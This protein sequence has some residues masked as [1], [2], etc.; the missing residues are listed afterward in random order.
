MS[1][2][3]ETTVKVS[4]IL[5]IVVGVMPLL[6]RRSAALRHSILSASLLCAAVIPVAQ[7][8][9]PSWH[10]PLPVPVLLNERVEGYGPAPHTVVSDR[11]A[12]DTVRVQSR[13]AP[14][15]DPFAL[16]GA[17]RSIWIAGTSL[18]VAVLLVGLWRLTRLAG[19][20]RPI[21]SGI[22][23]DRAEEICRGYGWRRP[24]TVLQSAH[25]T[26]L[27]TCGLVRP[28]IIL[29]EAARSWTDD[30]VRIVLYH[31]L[32]HVRRRDWI[33]QL[34]AEVVRSIYWF[35]PLVW[36]ACNRLRQESER[37]CDDAVLNRGVEGS[38]YATHLVD[39][40]RNLHQRRMWMPAPAIAPTSTLEKRVRAM[41]DARLSRRP[42]S[43]CASA[44]TL[45]ALLSIT[46]PIAGLAA[47]TAFATLTGSIVDPMN[48]A[49]PNVTL[50][51]TNAQTKA[52]YEIS[53]GRAGQYEFVGLPP[54]DYVLEA[55]L[56]G[57]AVLRG[58]VTLAGQ[59][60]QQDLKLEI[61]TIVE[62]V[63][64]RNNGSSA[65]GAP[66]AQQVRAPRPVT[67][68]G[69][70]EAAGGIP[71]GG[72]IRP[73]MKYKHV[74]P[75]YPASLAAATVQGTVVLQG[76]IGTSGTVDELNVL[77]S[78]NPEFAD[79]AAEAVRQWQFDTTLLNCVPVEVAIKVTVNFV[80]DA[81]R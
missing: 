64:V 81:G 73:P 63:T 65:G 37:A 80:P 4:L 29:P 69:T 58:N 11:T 61:G 50:V 2:L 77:S 60:V 43:R 8:V 3:V 51:L 79:A 24:V 52:K 40:A 67:C 25:P 17:L 66:Q 56:P 1:L 41:L 30:R 28:K 13:T 6:R 70:P 55:R 72:N 34:A 12:R 38:E 76:R 33:V 57:F 54:G 5:L 15:P 71:I 26:L 44:A 7:L 18:G 16:T 68:G 35:H 53:S 32:A 27:V 21:S 47:Q 9:V 22:W 45:I 36:I 23:M 19:A 62:T 20:A 10:L 78:P 14:T 48:A 59:K 42:V 49:L 46:I 74:A 31:E 75:V 39:I